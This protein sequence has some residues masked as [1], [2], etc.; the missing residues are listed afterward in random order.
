MVVLLPWEYVWAAHVGA[1][2]HAANWGKPDAPHYDHARMEDDRTAQMAGAVAELAVA[3]WLNRYWSGH[4]WHASEHGRF[5]DAPDV[6]ANV[7][8]RRVRTGKGAAV[9]RRQ[10]GK[11]LVLVAAEPVPPE[12]RVVDVWGWIDYDEAWALGE[13]SSYSD[14]TRLLG[15]DAFCVS[16]PGKS[17]SAVAAP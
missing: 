14:D 15:R 9:R 4:V 6:G 3:K 1:G 13:P 2:R 8:V 11:G 17:A 10:V 16:L 5:R 7:E 12:F